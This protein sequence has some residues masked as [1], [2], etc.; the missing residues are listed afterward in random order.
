MVLEAE[1][2][3]ALGAGWTDKA[4]DSFEAALAIQP[5]SSRITLDLAEAA[6]RNG[7]QGKA[8]HYYRR[9]LTSEPQNVDAIAGEGEALAEKGALEKARANLAKL[10]SLC[11]KD[12]DASEKLAAVIARGATP[13]LSAADVAPR[14]AI[15][16]N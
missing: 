9:V 3:D 15:S 6:R 4:I 7:M 16:A 14:A 8:L 5:G 11:G 10:E 12:C 2:G 1:G 13:K